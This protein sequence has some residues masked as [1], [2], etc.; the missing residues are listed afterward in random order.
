MQGRARTWGLPWGTAQGPG[1]VVGVSWG[2]EL[3]GGCSQSH[4]TA[5]PHIL[6][7]KAAAG[8]SCA[9][10][11]LREKSFKQ[12]QKLPAAFHLPAGSQEHLAAPLY[13]QSLLTS[14]LFL[15]LFKPFCPSLSERSLYERC[16]VRRICRALLWVFVLKGLGSAT[17]PTASWTH[18]EG[19]V[20][21]R[22]SSSIIQH[23]LSSVARPSIIWFI[24]EIFPSFPLKSL[25][26]RHQVQPQIS[27]LAP[28]NRTMQAEFTAV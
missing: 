26:E 20:E 8:R 7:R 19:N 17:N 15:R 27:T 1:I 11:V 3:Q 6:P 22:T 9:W 16:A 12:H 14:R 25:K 28:C 10:A 13:F 18:M 23:P 5:R 24:Q 2:W 21:L 4:C